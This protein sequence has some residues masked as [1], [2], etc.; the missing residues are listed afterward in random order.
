MVGREGT[1]GVVIPFAEKSLF[2]FAISP[3]HSIST[4]WIWMKYVH[5]PVDFVFY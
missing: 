4:F 2:S 5:M 1:G 3:S